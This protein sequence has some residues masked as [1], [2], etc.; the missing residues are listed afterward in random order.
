VGA[1]LRSA[2]SDHPTAAVKVG[3]VPGPPVAAVIV[4]VLDAATFAGPVVVDPVLAASSGLPLWDGPPAGLLPLLRRATLITP[5]AVELAALAGMPVTSADQAVAAAQTLRA[6]GVKAVLVKGGHLDPDALLVTD[7]LV[8][9]GGVQPFAR[10]RVPGPSP[11]G[12]GC[13]LSTALAA[14][15]ASGAS[16]ADAVDAAGRWL[17]D[18][19]AASVTVNGQL[20]LP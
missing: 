3:M 15:L 18:R 10:P 11:R 8:G 7:W 9:L 20:F 19:I 16:L 14:Q 17:A 5:N 2:L 4:G 6:L 12:T 13:A 1:A